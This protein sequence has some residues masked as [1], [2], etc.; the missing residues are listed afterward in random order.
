MN[1]SGVYDSK[2]GEL[3]IIQNEN[4]I[5]ATYQ[6]N[7]V[8]NGEINGNIISGSWKNTD[9]KGRTENGLFEWIFDPEGNFSGKYKIGIDEGSMRGK[10]DGTLKNNSNTDTIVIARHLEK[11]DLTYFGAEIA[12]QKLTITEASELIDLVEKNKLTTGENR[13]LS[14]YFDKP[15]YFKTGIL[16]NDEMEYISN[17]V[18]NDGHSNPEDID[19]FQFESEDCSEQPIYQKDDISKLIF[20]DGFKLITVRFED[21]YLKGS[22]SKNIP[23]YPGIQAIRIIGSIIFEESNYNFL[24]GFHQSPNTH[25][26]FNEEEYQLETNWGNMTEMRM[27]NEEGNGDIY[28]TYQ[29]LMYSKDLNIDFNDIY[30]PEE[31]KNEIGDLNMIV[32][33]NR[34]FDKISFIEIE[35]DLSPFK[36]DDDSIDLELLN[37]KISN[38]RGYL[39]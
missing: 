15:D 26:S 21:V 23:I 39:N 29:I 10:W 1:I 13:F 25:H 36:I 38:L 20:E 35:E 19:F 6:K 37:E 33:S 9:N 8:C 14:N 28:P 7:G 17:L 22:G 31:I 30:N 3:T 2:H 24:D 12:V 11:E 32:Y 34:E 4:K 18:D 27:D 16:L 5:T